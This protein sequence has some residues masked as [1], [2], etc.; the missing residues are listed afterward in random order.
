LFLWDFGYFTV[1]AFARI[2]EAGAYFFSRLTHQTN[3]YEMIA[4]RLTPIA[5]ASVLKTVQGHIVEKHIFIGA[6]D[7][8]ISRLI[9]SR[10]PEAK[11]NERRRVA[12]KNARKK[13]YTP[14]QAHL[15]LLSWHLFIT[16]VPCTIWHTV[17]VIKAYPL[18]WQIALLCKSWKS[19]LHFASI[20]TKKEATTLC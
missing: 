15:R 18:R 19:S 2:V 20:Q 3:I 4:G 11:G 13:G 7:H 17:T 12:S 10:V 9:A 8:V 5:L 16:N 14:S 6:K 1:Q